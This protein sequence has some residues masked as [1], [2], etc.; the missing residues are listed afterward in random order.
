MSEDNGRRRSRG[1]LSGFRRDLRKRGEKQM[2]D[3]MNKMMTNPEFMKA[4]GSAMTLLSRVNQVRAK[5]VKPLDEVLAELDKQVERL[6]KKANSLG[7]RIGEMETSL[8]K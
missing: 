4:A 5:G 6:Q 7:V 8:A 3:M 2:K 1:A